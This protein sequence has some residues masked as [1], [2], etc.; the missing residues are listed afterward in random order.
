MATALEVVKK[1]YAL[2]A[3]GDVDAALAQFD[4][5]CISVTPGAEL[6]QSAHRVE[7]LALK[8]AFPDA[9]LRAESVV[10]A[11]SAAAVFGVCEGTPKDAANMTDEQRARLALHGP[12]ADY[13]EVANGRIVAHRTVFDPSELARHKVTDRRQDDA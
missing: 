1:F 5:D 2:F 12:F 6:T 7:L 8:R 3:E 10:D 9:R 13:F 4:P 11:P